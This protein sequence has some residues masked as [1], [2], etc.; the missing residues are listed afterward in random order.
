MIDRATAKITQEGI[1]GERAHH[2]INQSADRLKML[3]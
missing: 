3:V 1:M 2:G